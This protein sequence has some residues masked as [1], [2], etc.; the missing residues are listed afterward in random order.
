[1]ELFELVI[2]DLERHGIN[3]FSLVERP[4]IESDLIMLSAEQENEATFQ[5]AEV[6][7]EEKTLVGAALIPNKRILRKRN[8]KEVEI[9][10]SE[11][12]V[13]KAAE[14]VFLNNMLGNTSIH[15]KTDVDDVKIIEGWVVED[16][17]MDKSAYHGFSFPKG[18][19]CIKMKCLSDETYKLAKEGKIKGISIEGLFGNKKVESGEKLS[20][21]H[22]MLK[23]ISEELGMKMSDDQIENLVTEYGE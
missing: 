20:G 15:H 23:E 12:T 1:M 3:K 18:T 21:V 13:R 4:A 16:S 14:L 8:G 10:F 17:Q 11:E 19:F 9:F 6:D 5:F 2:S 7:K 22:E